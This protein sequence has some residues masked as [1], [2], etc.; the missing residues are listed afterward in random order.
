MREDF[1]V[2]WDEKAELHALDSEQLFYNA[3]FMQAAQGGQMD[4]Q[5]FMAEMAEISEKK[6][7]VS[8]KYRKERDK[9]RVRRREE[10]KA[11]AKK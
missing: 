10:K 9:E 8:I 7:L 5:K 1:K 11:I 2:T 6:K 4:Q 3:L